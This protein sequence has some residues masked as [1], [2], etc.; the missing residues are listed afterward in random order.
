MPGKRRQ[1]E[2]DATTPP[3]KKAKKIRF[4][5]E[6]KP[7][8]GPSA[9]TSKKPTKV[10]KAK[11][12]DEVMEDPPAVVQTRVPI[13]HGDDIDFPRGG[14][15]GAKAEANEAGDDP[16]VPGN[17]D[18]FKDTSQPKPYVPR[19]QKERSVRT[20]VKSKAPQAGEDE[21]SL[22]IHNLTYKNL[23]PDVKILCCVISV[24]PLGLVVSLPGQLVGHI[25]VTHI[26]QIYTTR[27]A[28]ADEGEDDSP[29]PELADMFKP[30]EWLR[31][32]VTRV[33]APGVKTPVDLGAV[34]L[35]EDERSCARVELTIAPERVN[36]GVTKSDLI[37]GF[38][39][40]AVVQTIE[41][42]GYIID[43]GI[44]GISGFLSFKEA[45]KGPFE[46]TKLPVGIVLQCSVLTMSGNGR[47]CNVSVDPTVM[48]TASASEASSISSLLPG[49]L[50]SALITDITDNGINMQV[51]GL[52]QG[53][54][55]FHH[56]PRGEDALT[57]EALGRRVK[58]RVL[59]D[60][61]TSTPSRFALSLLPHVLQ[62]E[63][64][65]M[66]DEGMDMD[67]E[68]KQDDRSVAEAFP[69]GTR[70]DAVK[71]TRVHSGWGITCNVAKDVLG[72]VSI[73]DVAKEEESKP[74]SWAVNTVHPARVLG[75][76]P[77]DGVL[78]MTVQSQLLEE[79]HLTAGDLT[80]GQVV[81][82]T[83]K[84]LT[85]THM[86]VALSGI[87]SGI[88][89][90]SH[91][92]DLLLKHPEKKFVVGS[93]HKARVHFLDP[94]TNKVRLTMK[95]SLVQSELPIVSRFDDVKTGTVLHGTI[96]KFLD[97]AVLVE[98]FG[99]I[100]AYV[101]VK[102]L[103]DGPVY[104]I[105]AMF[106]IGQVVKTRITSINRADQKI[107]ASIRQALPSYEPEADLDSVNVGDNVKGS[108]SAVHKN[109]IRVTLDPSKVTALVSLFQLARHRKQDAVQTRL[110]IT[111]GEA[112]DG[113]VVA[114]KNEE[115][116]IVICTF[117][118]AHG[119][120]SVKNKA[121]STTSTSG[122]TTA[123][124]PT[125]R[126]AR[127]GS[128]VKESEL[129]AFT[130]IADAD[131]DMVEE[132]TQR[133][134][135]KSTLD[136]GDAVKA[137]VVR[138][139]HKR[140]ELTIGKTKAYLSLT[141]ISDNYD[142]LPNL[143]TGSTVEAV[144]IGVM[145]R[146]LQISLRKSRKA[147]VSE[148]AIPDPE[149][150]GVDELVADHKCRGFVTSVAGD[151]CLV[152]LGRK[153][154]ANLPNGQG[155]KP[156]QIGQVV[157]VQVLNITYHHVIVF[158]QGSKPAVKFDTDRSRRKN[159]E[160]GDQVDALICRKSPRGL[161]LRISHTAIKGMCRREEITGNPEVDVDQALEAFQVNDL[162]RAVILR[163]DTANNRV[164]F[165]LRRSRF[166]KDEASA[167]VTVNDTADSDSGD[168]QDLL[169]QPEDPMADGSSGEASEEEESDEE[170]AVNLIT[171]P[172]QSF[173]M[174][175]AG[176]TPSSNAPALK[177]QGG[178]QW[179]G[180]S[181]HD[182]DVNSEAEESELDDLP[183]SSRKKQAAKNGIQQDLTAQMHTKVPESSAD[184]ERMLRATPDSSFVWIQFMAFQLQL[185]E[186]EKA[187]EIG[188]R[189]L[190]VIN[191]R[192]EQEK[193]NVWIAL[194]N[195][196]V[197]YGTEET[198]QTVLYDAIR[199]NDAK[200]VHLRTAA[201]LDEAGK[202]EQAEAMYDR[203]TKKFGTS[204]KV[205][206]LFGEHYLRQSKP[207]DGRRLLP[208]SLKSLEK[209]KH[210]KTITRFA[211]LEYQLGDA[212]RGKTIFEGIIDSHPKRLDLWVVYM[213]Q[214]AKLANIDTLRNLYGR[215]FTQK[216]SA[217]KAKFFFKKWLE[218]ERSIG[219]EAGADNVKAKAVEWMEQNSQET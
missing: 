92:S 29:L 145:K 115:D 26:S 120:S 78:K 110:A 66:E 84:K 190:Q 150:N 70:M 3:I 138:K 152:A 151:H 128:L 139:T 33:Q 105:P 11:R 103:S 101:G 40:P 214:E 9:P 24:K 134:I 23:I 206:T 130:G 42:H 88:V 202:H 216:L 95:K 156:P 83:I 48:R 67:G 50:V 169:K 36:D 201:L 175:V 217:K 15:A 199:A 47:T 186:V 41:D 43:F 113:L 132:G 200:T 75:F 205:W 69:K 74:Q 4:D 58:A 203:A 52:F 195:L 112:I 135:T 213:D 211:L 167:L 21:P 72:F 168:D 146:Y 171:A 22:P 10:K 188:R 51:L 153:V 6:G 192:E 176:P 98:Y 56:V 164:L 87:L 60:I 183:S 25:P 170:E 35:T 93:V 133:A 191:F 161:L 2:I 30:G 189:A 198:L 38:T 143:A 158:L 209:R 86:I 59:Y 27:L 71:V 76:A 16:H 61:R 179:S 173:F 91:Y 187:R 219:N 116:R 154:T 90:P 144:V 204:S 63:T 1:N 141:D 17:D 140:V 37:P 34:P 185:S 178:F 122:T 97:N 162:V 44:A 172:S 125:Q 109:N 119:A 165:S 81:K 20:G 54:I 215:L 197:A 157:A 19:A 121:A 182:L 181:A 184:F 124:S 131:E 174:A 137:K 85:P 149:I 96:F 64:K 14:A 196:E 13:H 163:N 166:N 73:H 193:L 99:D 45:Q 39:L 155:D 111:T 32:V 107:W 194:L 7:K 5:D 123:A 159:F 55:S 147:P 49:T 142:E 53:T 18:L 31:A 127:W 57:D 129:D 65:H 208:R 212:E 136:I 102:E 114:K 100:K 94:E 62:L 80:V 106:S 46:A 126:K 207:D 77:V 8:D 218:T 118:N 104:S 89:F 117:A 12:H 28:T 82:V 210:L 68:T 108:I 148:A 160:V 177:I 79:A 180:P